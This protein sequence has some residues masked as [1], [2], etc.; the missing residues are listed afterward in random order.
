[1]LGR[2][3]SVM[4]YIRITEWSLRSIPY[5]LGICI[6]SQPFHVSLGARLIAAAY[7]RISVYLL[8]SPTCTC[9][10]AFLSSYLNIM[11]RFL[12][13]PPSVPLTS[14]DPLLFSFVCQFGLLYAWGCRGLVWCV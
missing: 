3:Y 7:C 12:H 2:E 9:I 1:M 10:E 14:R 8:L 13:S 4:P 5:T 6:P 11:L